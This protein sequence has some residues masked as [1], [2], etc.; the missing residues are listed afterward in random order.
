M[1]LPSILWS[2]DIIYI[3]NESCSVNMVYHKRC[4]QF[5]QIGYAVSGIIAAGIILFNV[6]MVIAIVRRNNKIKHDQNIQ[7]GPNL[8]TCSAYDIIKPNTIMA[9]HSLTHSTIYISGMNDNNENQV[10]NSAMPSTSTAEFCNGGRSCNTG[11][12]GYNFRK[13]K[14][15]KAYMT[16]LMHVGFYVLCGFPSLVLAA[17][18]RL[19][20]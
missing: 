14:N 17:D 2:R 18:K 6:A 5:V 10:V 1:I 4:K 19:L 3:P 8:H 12:N 13:S 9:V 7:M 15:F 20:F 11:T 16:V